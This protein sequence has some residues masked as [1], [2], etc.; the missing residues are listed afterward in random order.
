[1]FIVAVREL[2]ILIANNVLPAVTG[3]V[4]VACVREVMF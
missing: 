3:V 1:M 2:C 4:L